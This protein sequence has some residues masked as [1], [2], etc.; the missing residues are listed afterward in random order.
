M[1]CS[2]GTEPRDH[3][4]TTGPLWIY[5]GSLARAIGCRRTGQPRGTGLLRLLRTGGNKPGGRVAGT[6]IEDGRPPGGAGR[7]GAEVGPGTGTSRWRCWPTRIC[8]DQ[9]SGHGTGRKGGCWGTNADSHD[10]AGGAPAAHPPGMAEPTGDAPVLVVVET[11]PPGQ[12]P[13]LPL[14]PN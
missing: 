13:A 5:G 1:R 12:S 7:R 2:P 11:A 4:S 8:R 10:S 6:R 9:T 14:A 3:G